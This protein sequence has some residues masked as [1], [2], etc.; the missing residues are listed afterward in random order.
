MARIRRYGYIV[1]WFIGDHVPRHVHAYDAKGRFLGR[2][3][4]NSLSGVEDWKPPRALIKLIQ[5]LQNE[6]RL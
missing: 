4:V 3:D 1:E 5:E 6:G 2:I